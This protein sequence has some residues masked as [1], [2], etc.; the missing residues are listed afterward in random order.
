M[1]DARAGIEVSRMFAEFAVD[2]A[3]RDVPHEVVHEAKR[4]LID[5]LGVA[6]AGSREPLIGKLKRIYAK[7]G[8]EPEAR[9][10]GDEYKADVMTAAFINCAAGHALDFD[11]THADFFYHGSVTVAS[12]VWATG[13][14]LHGNG[15]DVIL[16]FIAG[17][18][19]GARIARAL[20]PSIY[21]EGWQNT[22]TCGTFAATVAAGR[23]LGLNADAMC[24]ALG[25]A[26][27][28]A[29]GSRQNHG[30][31]GKP[32]Q[33]G[34]AAMNGVLSA[35]AAR[36]GVT[37][38]TI[39][40]EGPL[41]FAKL[42]AR[43]F[44]LSSALDELGTRFE[45]QRNMYKPYACCLPHHAAIDAMF[46]LRRKHGVTPERVERIVC[47]MPA[48]TLDASTRIDEP[49]NGLEGKFSAT[50][51]AAVALTDDAAG[52]AQYA[53][54]RVGDAR[55]VPLRRAIEFVVDPTLS[56]GQCTAQ[57]WLRDGESVSVR[58]DHPRGHLAN[59]LTDDDL[60]DK[61]CANAAGMR[62]HERHMQALQPLW[63]LD[64]A[65]DIAEVADLL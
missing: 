34:K 29:S 42:H 25:M 51:S 27:S 43:E 61:F 10:I 22:P 62:H 16:A 41:G 53:D 54:E 13:Q 63:S 28:Q 35:L 15:R 19:V 30:S 33:V 31:M 44:D 9:L 64:A 2:L 8:G 32:F 37:S 36:E 49:A 6:L 26:A 45:L 24:H 52:L 21:I 20:N 12:A 1:D 55:L 65:D 59:P 60:V 58:V 18:D 56:R 39:A 50:H 14:M 57:A 17:W 7:R 38:S 11:D 47:G 4:A 23:L 5:Y 48:G 46:A 3:W 40:I